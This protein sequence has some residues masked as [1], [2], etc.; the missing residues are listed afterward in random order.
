LAALRIPATL[1]RLLPGKPRRHIIDVVK[2]L[3]AP[4]GGWNARDSLAAMKPLDAVKL[5]NWWPRVAD[6]AIRGGCSNYSTGYAKRIKTLMQ[7]APPTG[8]TKMLAATD[9]GIFDASAAGA[10]GAALLARTNGYHNWTQMAVSGGAYLIAPNGVDK[11]AYYDGA[12]WTAVDAAS[13]PALTGVTTTKLIAAN[14]YKRRLF[15][16]EKDKLNFW[17]LAAD[18]VGGALTEFLLG[19]LCNK[20]GYCM[21]TATWTMDSGAGPDDYVVFVS[22]EGECVV[23][24]GDNPSSAA[25]WLLKGV[26][27]VG[28]PIGRHCLKKYGGDLILLTEYGAFPLSKLLLSSTVNLKQALT[29]KIEGAFID[30]L[31]TNGGYTGWGLEIFP[32]QGALIVNGPTTSDGSVAVQYV[33]NTTTGA[34]AKF[35]GWAASDFTVFNKELYFADATAVVKA[36]TGHA[37]KGAYIVADG[38]TAFNNFGDVRTKQPSFFRPMLRVSGPMDYSQGLAVDFDPYPGLTTATYS[39]VSGAIWDQGLWDQV[40]W[41]AGLEVVRDWRTPECKPGEYLAGLVKVAT[42]SLDVQWAA[43]EYSYLLGELVG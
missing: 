4:I 24:T 34:W 32:A 8:S 36:W 29:N 16:L 43:N 6:V 19:P 10:V 30:D 40:Y 28:K 3:P 1:R 17:Y 33:M 22:S 21:A 23:F 13:A 25:A 35:T 41:A 42:N 38:Q 37:D 31:R 15:F 39:T 14:V 9:D 27:F 20:G 7:Y 12:V 18:A 26:Y 11:P 2:S 5:E